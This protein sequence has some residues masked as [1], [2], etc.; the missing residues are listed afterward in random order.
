[1]IKIVAT[2]TQNTN[3]TELVLVDDNNK[4]TATLMGLA[5]LELTIDVCIAYGVYRLFKAIKG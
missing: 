1:M 5:A 4:P 2:D 3:A